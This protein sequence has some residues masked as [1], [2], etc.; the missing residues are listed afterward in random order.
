MQLTL[1]AVSRLAMETPQT[2]QVTGDQI[3]A[4]YFPEASDSHWGP[5]CGSSLLV[6][7]KV[8]YC[9]HFLLF[10]FFIIEPT[11]AA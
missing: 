7:L 2:V 8:S 9:I 5:D 3:K 6:E 11:G 4:D 1:A 10:S